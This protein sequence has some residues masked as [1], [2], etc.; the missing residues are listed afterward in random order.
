MIVM[1][2]EAEAWSLMMLTSAI[3]IDNAGISEEGKEAIRRWRSDRNESSPELAQ[4]TD[5]INVAMNSHIDAKFMRR[6]KKKGGW[7]ETVKK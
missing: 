6:V 5:D 1:L 3:A 7:Y 2:E 4:L